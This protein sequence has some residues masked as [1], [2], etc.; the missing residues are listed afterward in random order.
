MFSLLF[1]NMGLHS[2]EYIDLYPQSAKPTIDQALRGVKGYTYALIGNGKEHNPSADMNFIEA[3][4]AKEIHLW[5][6]KV[7]P[8][9]RVGEN[10]NYPICANIQI[11][12]KYN[13]NG[14]YASN[15]AYFWNVGSYVVE[16]IFGDRQ[17]VYAYKLP[18]FSVM[19]NYFGDHIVFNHFQDNICKFICRYDKSSTLQLSKIMTQWREPTLKKYFD[20]EGDLLE[21]I[22]ESINTN[23][24]GHTN[25][26]KLAL[27]KNNDESLKYDYYL[28]YLD[29]VNCYTDW[30]EGEIKAFLYPTSTLGIYKTDWLMLDKSVNSD[31]YISIN[32]S[33]FLLIDGTSQTTYLKLYPTAQNSKEKQPKKWQGTGFALN[34]GYVVTNYHVANNAKNILI[35]QYRG[36]GTR[37]E[38]N[39]KLV[40]SDKVNDVA[41]LK[42][43]DPNFKG[44]GTIPYAIKSGVCEVGESVWALGFPMADIMGEEIKFTDGKISARSG[45]DGMTSVY[46]ISVPIQHGNSGGPL[47]DTK[48]NIVGITSSGLNR[49]LQTENVNYAIKSS[50]LRLLIENTLPMS[51]IPQGTAMQGQSLTTQIKLAKKYVFY[52][53]CSK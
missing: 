29:G 38:Y 45:V 9:A 6:S 35:Y 11:A 42:I 8:D 52:I 36:D 33:S 14:Y 26:Y 50:Y 39:A 5:M 17:Y 41:I 51:V 1:T 22:Y 25:K 49:D 30:S 18:S 13:Y 32:E 40:A 16:I 23:T 19:G 47:F 34:S 3:F 4:F 15:G 31:Y 27:K 46:Q 12:I 10:I 2:D 28:I 43:D 21:G 7:C 37:Q 53:E 48:G 44:F 24:D 20:E